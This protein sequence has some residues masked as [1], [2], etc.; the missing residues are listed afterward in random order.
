MKKEKK[1]IKTSEWLYTEKKC[2]C[3]YTCIFI[4]LK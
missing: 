1:T 2:I 4:L 3:V